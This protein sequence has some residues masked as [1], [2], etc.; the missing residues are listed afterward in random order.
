MANTRAQKTAQ[1]LSTLTTAG[2]IAYAS[3]AG[4]PARLGIGTTGQVVTVASG[5][6]SWAT[7]AGAGS[8]TAYT[9]VVTAEAGTPSSLNSEAG[10]YQMLNSNT[11]L[12]QAVWRTGSPLG[13]PNG[14]AQFTLP[15]TSAASKI[16]VGTSYESESTGYMGMVRNTP[17]TA[18]ARA[19]VYNNTYWWVVNYTVTCQLIYE[20]A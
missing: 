6:P 9:P 1:N 16:A 13:N 8:W 15:F 10:R 12:V 20:V 4:T 7:A 17:S 11:C 19:A 2:D 18:Y 3:A 5:L 14:Y